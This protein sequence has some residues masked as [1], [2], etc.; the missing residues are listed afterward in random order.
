MISLATTI[1]NDKVRANIKACLDEDRIGQGRFIEEFEQKVADYVGVEY[2]IAVCNGTMANAVALRALAEIYPGNEVI[3]PAL[4]FVAQINS[5]IMSGLKPVFIDIGDDLQMTQPEVNENTLCI[6]SANLM[7]KKC[8]IEGDIVLEDSC[9]A[10]GLKPKLIGTYSFYP[11]HTITTGE[12]G[13]IVTDDDKLAKLCKR[14]RNHGRKGDDI[15][16]KF[17]FDIFGFNAKMTN[18][19][20]AIG[21]AVIGEADNIIQKRKENV[22]LMNELVG[23]DFYAESPHGYPVFYKNK[24]ERDKKLIALEGNQIEARKLF[25]CSIEGFP[26]A[27]DMGDRGLFVP[28]H[29]NLSEEDIKKISMCLRRI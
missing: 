10:F 1:I 11:A 21:C 14:I 18:L 23:Q 13:M 17:E 16:N 15:L 4:T 24:E 9:E 2:A 8:D 12:G 6:M 22:L 27:K 7:G 20:A 25:G 26:K 19:S 5:V 28:I 3:V 29:Q